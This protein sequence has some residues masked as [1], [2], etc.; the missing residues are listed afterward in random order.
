M[1]ITLYLALSDNSDILLGQLEKYC[2]KKDIFLE[3]F[4]EEKSKPK[5]VIEKDILPESMGENKIIILGY[6]KIRQFMLNN[7]KTNQEDYFVS[8]YGSNNWSRKLK[9]DPEQIRR[10]TGGAVIITTPVHLSDNRVVCLD[11][12][13]REKERIYVVKYS[14]KPYR[15]FDGNYNRHRS[16][17]PFPEGCIICT[18]P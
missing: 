14:L 16:G 5:M 9:A 17:C 7:K 2:K 15:K 4:A 1:K 8:E 11:P 18:L 12:E 10:N 6:K 13:K 3:A